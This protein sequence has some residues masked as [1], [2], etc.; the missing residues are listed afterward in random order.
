MSA[1]SKLRRTHPL[2]CRS[3]YCRRPLATLT[4]LLIYIVA[5]KS[6]FHAIRKRQVCVLHEKHAS[7][8][9]NQSSGTRPE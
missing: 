9:I 8:I 5:L 6:K 2:D 7:S 1:A 3:R 4:I